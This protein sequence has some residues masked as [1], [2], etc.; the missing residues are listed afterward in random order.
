MDRIPDETILAIVAQIPPTDLLFVV[1]QVSRRLRRLALTELLF[2]AEIQI[3]DSGICTLPVTRAAV[4]LVPFI[5]PLVELLVT[6]DLDDKSELH[7]LTDALSTLGKVPDT[8]FTMNYGCKGP[9]GSSHVI[10]MTRLLQVCIPDASKTILILE[11]GAFRVSRPRRMKRFWRPWAYP[12]E[13]LECG[14]D[15]NEFPLCAFL[16]SCGAWITMGVHTNCLC[17]LP[18]VM[19]LSIVVAIQ[20]IA[21]IGA[22]L[23]RY[24]GSVRHSQYRRIADDLGSRVDKLEILEMDIDWH[25]SSK[26]LVL[27]NDYTEK[28]ILGPVSHLTPVKMLQILDTQDLSGL[29]ELVIDNDLNLEMSM[30]ILF[31]S[32]HPGIEHLGFGRR[33]LSQSSNPWDI[34]VPD[35]LFGNLKALS[36]PASNISSLLL[37]A[38]SFTRLDSVFIDTT[39]AVSSWLL[40]RIASASFRDLDEALRS[41]TCLDPQPSHLG[42]IFPSKSIQHWLSRKDLEGSPECSLGGVFRL[43]LGTGP[44]EA[45]GTDVLE[46]LSRWIEL[47]PSLKQKEIP[48]KQETILEKWL[49]PQPHEPVPPPA[50]ATTPSNPDLIMIKLVYYDGDSL[51]CYIKQYGENQSSTCL[52]Q[53]NSKPTSNSL[54]DEWKLSAIYPVVAINPPSHENLETVQW[55]VKAY[56]DGSLLETQTNLKV[57]YLFWEAVT[58][59]SERPASP[60]EIAFKPCSARLTDEN[61]ILFG[62]RDD[63]PVS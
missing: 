55:K 49:I 63:D 50:R 8:V 18:A 31:L 54:I 28:L 21:D 59:H 16:E 14:M 35:G 33:S 53:P 40:R 17:L 58:R 61:S 56:P 4:K 38:H 3:S 32:R 20:S 41:M 12:E 43:T 6:L 9:T 60:S 34:V 10:N 2:Q 36:G 44:G 46:A 23:W 47:F 26:V 57:S 13:W 30:F 52:H 24:P 27:N 48:E 45:F 37:H 25:Y 15:L 51:D 1:M 19:V 29:K 5:Q 42:L 11:R 62:R 22:S 39:S 7:N